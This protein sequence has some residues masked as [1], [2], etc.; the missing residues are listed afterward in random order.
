MRSGNGFSLIEM[1]VAMVIL[2]LSLGVL[3]QASMGATRNVR[4][5]GE[6]NEA[7]I[8][9]ESLISEQST[10]FET[11]VTREGAWGEYRWRAEIIEAAP[12]SEARELV[13]VPLATVV[14]TVYW[15]DD[16]GSGRPREL[17]LSSVF[18]V[19]DRASVGAR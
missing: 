15:G 9:G 7:L 12:P 16:G 2:S 17:T 11:G 8:L 5:A 10:V 1:M 3:Y 4:V 13:G 19:A 14:V 18:P 6:Y